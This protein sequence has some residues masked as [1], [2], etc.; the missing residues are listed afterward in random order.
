MA[1]KKT[2][3]EKLGLEPVEKYNQ[4]NLRKRIKT[5]EK[6]LKAGTYRGEKEK[7]AASYLSWFKSKLKQ[8]KAA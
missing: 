3:V 6:N 8:I 2:M 5:L 7:K 1:K 4:T